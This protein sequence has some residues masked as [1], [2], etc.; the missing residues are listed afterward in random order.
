MMLPG[1][2][3]STI[4]IS[5]IVVVALAAA[6]ALRRRSAALRHAVLAAAVVCAAATPI[7]QVILP[8]WEMRTAREPI[9]VPATLAAPPAVAGPHTPSRP[10]RMAAIGHLVGPIW[11]SGAALSLCVLGVGLARLASIASRARLV[12]DPRWTAVV[13]DVARRY[14]IGTRVL[15]L[16]SDHP[17]LLVTWGLVRPKVMLPHVARDWTDDRARIVISHE[18]AHIQ[19]R[20][21]LTQMASEV[22]RSICWFN[23][24]LWIAGRRLRSESEHA[25]DDAVLSLGV[26]GTE[27]A[28]ALVDLAR[29]FSAYRRLWQPGS[30]APAMARP[31]SLE[32]RIRAMLNGRLN[33]TPITRSACAAIVIALLAVT[34][35]LAGF[36]AAAQ[37][38]SATFSG[39]LVDEMGRIVPD[40][41][42]VLTHA[43]T[44]ATF[45]T[46]SDESGRF[47]FGALPAGAYDLNAEKPAFVPHYRV[48]LPAGENVRRDVTLLLASLEETVSVSDDADAQRPPLFQR[49]QAYVSEPGTDACS[50]SPIGG[51]VVQPV[52]LG[53]AQPQ[54]PPNL[55][56]TGKGATVVLRAR[57]GTDGFMKRV[58]VAAPA[59]P[60]F[61]QPALDAVS[62]WQFT[63]TRLDGVAVEVP[64]RVTVHFGRN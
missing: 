1:L 40:V 62:Q 2:L 51:C 26:D 20:D 27:Y 16:Q 59:D 39:S 38:G 55:H 3:D 24:L 58:Q 8:S 50:Q 43:A 19:R 7:L 23:P 5:L 14:G 53:N 54:Y 12:V 9:T 11:M 49:W 13:D 44:G 56:G 6:A 63:T 37:S 25:C 32:R 61:A 36:G 22:L 31:S 41:P 17:T 28:A 33:R 57:I 34:L 64:M 29:T 4:K 15:L 21:W 18:L 42:M 60:D 47:Q 30:P 52:K 46:R 45:E 48:T 35:P 10:P